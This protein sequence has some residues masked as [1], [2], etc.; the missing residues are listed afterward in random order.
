MIRLMIT[1]PLHIINLNMPL[2]YDICYKTH[3]IY[4]VLKTTGNEQGSQRQ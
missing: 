4:P 2:F 3:Y 1:K